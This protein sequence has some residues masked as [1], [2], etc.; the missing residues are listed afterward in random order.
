M[1]LSKLIQHFRGSVGRRSSTVVLLFLPLLVLPV[2]ASADTVTLFG[3]TTSV[4]VPPGQVAISIHGAGGLFSLHYFNP[5]YVGPLSSSFGFQSITQGVGSVS[6]NGMTLQYLVGSLSFTNSS[7][8][9]QVS[10]FQT[11]NDAANNNPAFVAMFSGR[12]VL[13]ST[14]GSQTFTVASPTPEP[15]SL[16]LLTTGIGAAVAGLRTRRKKANA[17]RETDAFDRIPN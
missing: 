3:G 10:G 11:L 6:Y 15:A 16:V 13:T 8:T 4:R 17:H 5:E 7:L 1:I 14:P 12:G 2:S 9:G